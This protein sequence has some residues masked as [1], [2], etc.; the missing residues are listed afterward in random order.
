M[1]I[2]EKGAGVP[3]SLE[4]ER[5]EGRGCGSPSLVVYS[6]SRT[7]RTWTKKQSRVYNSLMSFFL[8]VSSRKLQTFRVDL[9]TADGGIP[10][11]LSDDHKELRKRVKRVFGYDIEH[12]QVITS[13]GNGV[14]HGVWAI[15]SKKSAY[16]PQAWISEQWESIHG[17]KIVWIERVHGKRHY[18]N[19][20]QYFA[21]HYLAGQGDL[22]RHS[23]SWHKCKI[24]L[25]RGWSSF[26]RQIS[27]RRPVLYHEQRY[28][29]D[30]AIRDWLPMA[31]IVKSWQSLIELGWCLVDGIVY[32]IEGRTVQP[33]Y[34]TT[35]VLAGECPF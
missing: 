34:S 4:P 2:T 7:C 14:M 27:E 6:Q 12:Y 25:G 1:T 18:K 21:S 8:E 17:A 33:K 13:E 26:K 22:V 3:G 19:S 23:Y 28:G 29:R 5:S 32:V 30:F 35:I 11:N 16:I 10:E 24:S 9:T 15:E 31:E 20:A